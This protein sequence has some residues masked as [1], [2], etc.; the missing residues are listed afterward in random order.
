[1]GWG[2]AAVEQGHKRQEQDHIFASKFFS[3]FPPLKPRCV[4][5]SGASYSPKDMVRGS[6]GPA[7]VSA[8]Q[9]L[10]GRL[11]TP[12]CVAM[13]SFNLRATAENLTHVFY[14]CVSQ[15]GHR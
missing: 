12:H 14:L 6:A 15:R 3:Y 5:W 7:F 2:E 13:V 10:G 4:L 8:S 1:M 9:L 11:T